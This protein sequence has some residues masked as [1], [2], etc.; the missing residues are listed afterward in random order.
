MGNHGATK[1]AITRRSFVGA[2]AAAIAGLA[3]V[4]CQPENKLEEVEPQ[5]EGAMAD[6]ELDPTIEG[7]W[8]TACCNNNCGGMCLNR[9]YVV[10]GVVVRQKTDDTTEDSMAAPQ[11][12]ACPR[13]RSKK[14]HTFGA[15]LKRHD[16]KREELGHV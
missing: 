7:K 10:D 3:M 15:D 6:A 1:N 8:V 5:A 4:G 2:S 16:S 13:G 9:V 14:Q 11:L 12:R